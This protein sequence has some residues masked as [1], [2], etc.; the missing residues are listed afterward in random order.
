[1]GSGGGL[2]DVDLIY[3][4]EPSAG[5]LLVVGL[6]GRAVAWWR[7]R[8]SLV[9]RLGRRSRAIRPDFFR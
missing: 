1:M 5:M 4:P 7:Q 2:G 8:R 6:L 9:C 3:V